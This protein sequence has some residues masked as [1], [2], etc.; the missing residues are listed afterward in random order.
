MFEV[1]RKVKLHDEARKPIINGVNKLADAVKVT[2]GPK[3]RNVVID[4]DLKSIVTKDGVTVAKHVVLKDRLENL[5]AAIL[6]Q[7]AE[8]T[9]AV[10]G[11][12]TTTSTVLAQAL[13]NR[14]QRYLVSGAAPI[15]MKRGMD[16]AVETLKKSLEENSIKV[17]GKKSAL[18]NVAT[19]S[20]NNDK[21][22]GAIVAKAFDKSGVDGVITVEDSKTTSTE[23]EEVNGYQFDRGYVS[24]YFVTDTHKMLCEYENPYI[25]LYDGK[26]NNPKILIE[27]MEMVAMQKK[28][29]L[30][31][32]EE[33]DVQSI[34]LLVVNKMQ[35]GLPI[36]AV[37]SPSY[38][39]RKKDM[40]YDMAAVTG[41]TVVS[42]D[43]GL[44][45]DQVELEHLGRAKKIKVS[46][47]DTTII[48]GMGQKEEID[49]RIQELK[50]QMKTKEISYLKE[51]VQQR[52]A[53][54]TNG[55]CI[56]KAGAHTEI[57]LTE[58]KHRLDDAIKATRCAL[59]SGIVPGA[60]MALYN[61]VKDLEIEMTEDKS[62]D[63]WTGYDLVVECAQEPAKAILRNSGL[64][65][66]VILA[67]TE[68]MAKNSGYNAKTD[69][70]VDL[71]KDGVIDPTLVVT[72]A[73]EN[74]VSVAGM[75][76]TTEA[77]LVQDENENEGPDY[78]PSMMT[79]M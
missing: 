41:G 79:G 54:L 4:K 69:Q 51:Q 57:E 75:I 45:L 29:F 53:K 67:N 78:D 23:I 50:E 27:I 3:G 31:I 10:A 62:E 77:A 35:G 7:A 63:Y 5:G 58:I 47:K 13:V 24:P 28:P 12:G 70:Y 65:P 73:L 16:E 52:I 55:V 14:G 74:A 33:L 2:L 20:A 46:N 48:E 38:A 39:Q 11:D 40:L 17:A 9:A 19:I 56:I 59:K 72:S 44:T 8:K 43:T 6:K 30:I 25:L 36:V 34:N 42:V 22:L 26:I 66:E 49:Q 64:N 21:K 15:E 32:A 60:G 61:A 37:K 76:L 71:V 68:S 18:E 1:T